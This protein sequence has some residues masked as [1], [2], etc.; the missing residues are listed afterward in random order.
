MVN[1]VNQEAFFDWYGSVSRAGL[2]DKAA[3]LSELFSR[4][5]QTGEERFTLTAEQTKSGQEESFPFRFENVG[6][7]GASTV[8]I[9]FS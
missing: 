7:C 8:F 2:T 3:L 5:C 4:Y 1:Y 9:Y 6:C